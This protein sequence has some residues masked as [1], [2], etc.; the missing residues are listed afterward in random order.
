MAT[1]GIVETLLRCVFSPASEAIPRGASG[2]QVMGRH[3][4]G[5]ARPDD[6]EDRVEHLPKV[7]GA[8]S[9]TGYG[10]GDQRLENVL[11]DIGEIAGVLRTVHAR[12]FTRSLG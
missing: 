9:T 5:E 11:L 8:R 6:R 4:S 12:Q 1:Q 3:P 10:R 2:N 7:D